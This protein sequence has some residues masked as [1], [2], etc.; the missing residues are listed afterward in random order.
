MAIKTKK[1]AVMALAKV[2]IDKRF[3]CEGGCICSSLEELAECL[4]K[5]HPD[6]YH[7]H[8][9]ASGNDFSNWVR[10]VLGD[11]KLA[12]DLLKAGDIKQTGKMIGER[13]KWLQ[14]KAS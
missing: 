1:E 5:M 2:N 10:Y 9:T 13:I 7:H 12:D 11:D 14:K 6:T 8:V 3:Y 4:K